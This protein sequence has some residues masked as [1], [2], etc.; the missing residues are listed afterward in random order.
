MGQTGIDTVNDFKNGSK[1]FLQTRYINF[2]LGAFSN[3]LVVHN[4]KIDK[5]LNLVAQFWFSEVYVPKKQ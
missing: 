3:A 2:F 4:R 5:S 1:D